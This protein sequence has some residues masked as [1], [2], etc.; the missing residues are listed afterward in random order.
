MIGWGGIVRW[1]GFHCQHD[2]NNDDLV[3][4]LWGGMRLDGVS[5]KRLGE[6]K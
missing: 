6:I 1:G 5:V 2:D 3:E 4:K